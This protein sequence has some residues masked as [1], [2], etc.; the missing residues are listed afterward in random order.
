MSTQHQRD[1]DEKRCV[2]RYGR[3]SNERLRKSAALLA[4][5]VGGRKSHNIT[6]TRQRG[7]KLVMDAIAKTYR[8]LDDDEGGS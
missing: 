2:R 7:N 3:Y 6:I 5:I 1:W 8:A 4:S